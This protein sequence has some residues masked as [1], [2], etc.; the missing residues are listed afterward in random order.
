MSLIKEV[1]FGSITIDLLKQT[2]IWK[3]HQNEEGR[4]PSHVLRIILETLGF[5]LTKTIKK[6]KPFS[7]VKAPVRDKMNPS[8]AYWTIVFS[9]KIKPSCPWIEAFKKNDVVSELNLNKLEIKNFEVTSGVDAEGKEFGVD[10]VAWRKI[11]GSKDN[12]LA[13]RYM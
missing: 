1:V 9:G 8:K 5:D 11:Q 2:N 6:E 12:S 4:V 13:M 7:S 10:A 3:E